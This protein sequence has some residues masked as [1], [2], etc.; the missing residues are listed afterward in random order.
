M[1]KTGRINKRIKR[2]EDRFRT[3]VSKGIKGTDM[4]IEM[5]ERRIKKLK[6]KTSPLGFTMPHSPLNQNDS[7]A[8][9]KAWKIDTENYRKRKFR[10]N[11]PKLGPITP[12]ENERERIGEQST[13]YYDTKEQRLKL[14]PT[15]DAE[16]Q[17]QEF[18]SKL[19]KWQLPPLDRRSPLNQNEKVYNIFIKSI[20]T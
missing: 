19:K 5:H 6:D 13:K 17:D 20:Y 14:I 11:N 9:S 2:I 12:E 1:S 16:R 7:I 8:A 4:D 18:K 10:G 15:D 3:K